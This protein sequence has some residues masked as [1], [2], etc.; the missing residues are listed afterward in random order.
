MSFKM[1]ASIAYKE[2]LTQASPIILE[3]IGTLSAFVP[4]A[5]TGDVMG[6]LNKRRGRVM[7]MNPAEKGMQ[8]IV[9]EVPMSE[10]FDFTTFLRSMTQGRGYFTLEFTR[11]DPLPSAL[12]AKVIEDA[13][14]LNA[15]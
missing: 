13:K 7:G 6:E 11:Y 1:A 4:D 5:N 15:D 8:E 9:A 2:G 12:E 14:A 3:P 10:M